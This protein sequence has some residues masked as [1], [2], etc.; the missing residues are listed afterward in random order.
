LAVG[1]LKEESMRTC[2]VSAGPGPSTLRSVACCFIAPPDLL[3]RLADEGTKEQRAAALSTLAASASIRAR[4]TL[5]GQ[6]LRDPQTRQAALAFFGAPA[7]VG[8]RRRVHDVHNGGQ[9]ALPGKLVR[10][11][12]DSPSTDDSANEAFDGA[13]KT[14]DFYEQ[15][16]SRNSIDGQ[17]MEIV[18]SVHFGAD[19]DNAFWNGS[20][21]VYGDGSGEL[22]AVGALTKSLDV[23]GH[24][25]THGVTQFTAGL[26]YHTQPGALNESMSDVFGSLIKQYSLKQSADQADWLIGEGTLVPELGQALRSMKEPG[27]A[28]KWDTQPGHMRDYQEL[29]DDNDPRHDNGGV[30][31]NSGIPNKAFYL[32]ASAIGGN[33]WEKAGPIWYKA[34]TEKFEPTTDFEQAA[35][36]TVEAAGELYAEG[37]EQAAVQKAWEDVGVL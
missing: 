36:L 18:S 20:Q 19:Y 5:I 26:E 11:E 12:D 22:F 16:L 33:A 10:A 30:H 32:A 3:A 14:Y 34:L 13:G 6:L 17:G 23:I 28:F 7:A 9:S 21:M 24:E 31:I 37:T 25:L 2:L 4:R 29:P 35:K 27:T 15:T 1:Q 8:L